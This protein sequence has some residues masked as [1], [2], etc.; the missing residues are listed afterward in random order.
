MQ[1]HAGKEI[2]QVGVTLTCSNWTVSRDVSDCSD[3]ALTNG[4]FNFGK[5]RCG[6]L[7]CAWDWIAADST[8][9][10][11]LF[12]VFGTGRTANVPRIKPLMAAVIS[13]VPFMTSYLWT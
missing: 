2:G 3:G 1:E 6:M 7:S 4:S 8:R 12:S 5:G 9:R 11:S 13:H 10:K